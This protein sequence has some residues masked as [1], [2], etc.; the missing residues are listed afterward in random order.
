MP[1]LIAMR[2]GVYIMLPEPIPTA[3]YEV[4]LISSTSTTVSQIVK[5]IALTL[6]N[7]Q[8][9]LQQIWYIYHAI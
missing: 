3:T 6:T 8:T 1:A 5:I 7:A 4:P 2:I 9:N